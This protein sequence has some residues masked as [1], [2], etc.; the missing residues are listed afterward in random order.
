MYNLGTVGLG[1]WVKR[2]H[3]VLKQNQEIKLVKTVGTRPFNEKYEE[4]EGY[5]ISE[6]RYYRVNPSDP[7]PDAFFDGLD[8]VHIAS[9]NQ[10]HKSQAIQS[11]AN[12]KLTMV[13][14]TFATNKQDFD[15]IL[16]YIQGNGLENKVVL[17]L[18]YLSKALTSLL[19]TKL[20]EL[21]ENYGK[22]TGIS[23]TFFEKT[24]NEDAR[25][26]WL[27]KPENGGVFMDWVHPISI[28]SNVL[29]AEGWKLAQAQ[30]F[31]V[32]PMYDMVNPT[33]V[34]AKF[35]IKGSNFKPDSVIQIRVGKGFDVEHRRFRINFENGTVD[36]SYP[37][38]ED[39]IKKG[40]R[41]EMK[42]ISGN[43]SQAV[44]QQGPLSYEITVN[45][46]L[47]MLKGIRSSLNLDDIKKIYEPEWQFQEISKDM[48]PRNDL[49]E[50]QTFIKNGLANG[51]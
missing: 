32:Q 19:R 46:T 29:K 25:R 43:N 10:F 23:A 21:I 24:N 4:L 22:I 7:L 30:S 18:H 20:T 45:E 31:I 13:E 34:E 35:E 36:L 14:K 15:E 26:N 37:S 47:N 51:I 17:H 16:R 1:H 38:T 27:F 40:V 11:L 3:E 49:N 6:D 5:G 39:E 28:T 50:I 42:I 33:A 12:G 48:H 8:I 41:G 9:P 2:L 44:I